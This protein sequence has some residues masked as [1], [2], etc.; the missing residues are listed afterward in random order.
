V[1]VDN[2]ENPTNI[3]CK[4]KFPCRIC[5]G[6]HL[7][8]HFLGIPKVLEV[9]SMGSQQPVSL[10]STSHTG[11]NPSTSDLKVGGKKCKVGIG[12]VGK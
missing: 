6:D 9:C 3:G 4:L 2:V 11:D 10:A 12:Y 8:N 1:S 7:L 5:K